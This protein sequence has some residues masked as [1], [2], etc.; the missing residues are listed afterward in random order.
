MNKAARSVAALAAFL[1]ATA[2]LALHFRDG[3]P[4]RVTGGFGEDSC[5]ACHSGNALNQAGGRLTLSGIPERYL[6]GATYELELTLSRPPK[7]AAAGFQLAIR[8]AADKMQAGT[9]RLSTED[10]P[11]M[12]LLDERGVQFAHHRLAEAAPPGADSVRWKLSWTAPANAGQVILHA[13]AVAGDGDDSQLG[14]YVYKLEAATEPSLV[15]APSPDR[16]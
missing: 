8:R 2:L 5:L 6:P 15:M 1:P 16:P 7:L 9:I 12:G 3:P 10:E 11:R 14:D 13:A 4:A